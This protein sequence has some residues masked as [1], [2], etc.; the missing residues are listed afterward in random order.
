MQ[1]CILNNRASD[2][3]ER[4]ELVKHLRAAA[5]TKHDDGE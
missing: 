2:V 3:R 4:G 1:N 5:E